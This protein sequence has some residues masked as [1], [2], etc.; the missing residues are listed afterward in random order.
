MFG[1]GYWWECLGVGIGG[2]VWDW[3]LVGMFTSG[4]WWKFFGLG[5]GGNVWEWV[6]VGM[7]GNGYWH[8]GSAE[9]LEEEES[10]LRIILKFIIIIII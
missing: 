5:I 6:L 3:V 8:V 1:S 7:F 9:E 2:N 10:E 4:Y